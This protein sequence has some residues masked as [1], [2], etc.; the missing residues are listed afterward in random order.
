MIYDCPQH[1]LQVGYQ[2]VGV[3][4]NNDLKKVLKTFT[5]SY[6]A[7]LLFPFPGSHPI[8]PFGCENVPSK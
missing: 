7:L 5:I 4:V 6:D 2:V 8:S 3:T 1:V